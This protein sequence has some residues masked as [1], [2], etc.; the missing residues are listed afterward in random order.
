MKPHGTIGAILVLVCG[1][2]FAGNHQV[3][4]EDASSVQAATTL[5]Q[6]KFSPGPLYFGPSYT[7]SYDKQ[8]LASKRDSASIFLDAGEARGI[9]V[10][11]LQASITYTDTDWHFYASATFVGGQ[12]APLHRLGEGRI[13]CHLKWGCTFTEDVSVQ[14]SRS[15]L[16]EHL[17]H[18]FSVAIDSK[19]GD[20]KVIDI[21][22]S[23]VQGFLAALPKQAFPA[24]SGSS[25]A[26]PA[27]VP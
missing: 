9:A 26:V 18:G 10:Y 14:L 20:R 8:P 16:D 2:A 19:V 22:A 6:D 15:F 21:S 13:H 27:S 4:I 12:P 1:S 25:A 3:N 11:N 7:I 24:S 5:Q 17:A 23:Y